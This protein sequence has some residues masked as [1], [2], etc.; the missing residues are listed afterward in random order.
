M[1]KEIDQLQFFHELVAQVNDKLHGFEVINGLL[2]MP[3]IF[4]R[5]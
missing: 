4:T 2:Q 3:I 5:V 1:K